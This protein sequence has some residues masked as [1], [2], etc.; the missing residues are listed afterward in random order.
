MV[1]KT[2]TVQEK[3]ARELLDVV[4]LQLL[5]GQP[6][7]GYQIIM[8]IRRNFGVY[9]GPSTIY[10]LLNRLEMEK[11]VESQWD[12]NCE[13][14]RKVYKLTIEGQNLLEYTKESI[15]LICKKLGANGIPAE[16]PEQETSSVKVQPILKRAALPQPTA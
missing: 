4:I 13:R 5:N 10:P 3:L 14:P 16:A 15:N 2:K 1:V 11:Y 8:T 9:L 6:M 7:H 12:M